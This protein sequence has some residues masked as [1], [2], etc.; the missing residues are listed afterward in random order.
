[1]TT[2]INPYNFV[3]FDKKSPMVAS[4]ESA[5]RGKENQKNLLSGWLEIKLTI[6]TPLIVPD[7]AHP[8]IYDYKEN[9]YVRYIN[10]T[11]N[12]H[13]EYSFMKIFNP[14]TGRKEYQIPG[15]ELRGMIRSAYEAVTNSCLPFLMDDKPMSQRVPLYGA[16]NRR[17][18]LQ[19]DGKRWVLYSTEKT[20]EE[21]VVVPVYEANREF[22]I[23][24]ISDKKINE[25]N[26]KYS[27]INN[28]DDIEEALK[29]CKIDS[30]PTHYG[31]T[32]KTNEKDSKKKDLFVDGKKCVS[33]IDGKVYRFLFVKADGSF[34]KQK[35][36]TY[37]DG[38]GWIQYNVPVD[39]T[40]VYH[41]AYLNKTEIVH[42]WDNNPAKGETGRNRKPD[43]TTAEAYYKLKSSLQRDGAE[44]YRNGQRVN[45]QPNRDCNFAIEEAL[46][47]AC[48]DKNTFVPVY[49]FTVNSDFGEIVYMSGSA[50]G[51][52]A[53]RRKWA[54]IMAGH[55]TCGKDLCPACLLFGTL[56]DGGMKTHI[57]I[58]DAY[59]EYDGEVRKSI[60][61]L[62][63]LA[64]PRPTAFEFYLNKPKKDNPGEKAIYSFWNYDFYGV[65]TENPPQ[66][67]Y[68]HLEKALPRGRKMYWHHTPSMENVT[69]GRMNSTMESIDEGVFNFKVYYDQISEKQLKDLI[70]VINLGENEEDGIMRHKLGHAKPLGYGSV[71][72]TIT[73][74]HVRCVKSGAENDYRM[75]IK[76]ISEIGINPDSVI[77]DFDLHSDSVRSFLRVCN[78]ETI[79]EDMVVD[80]PRTRENGMIYEWFSKNR[81]N[82]KRLQTLPHATDDN[83]YLERIKKTNNS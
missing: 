23:E 43:I 58:S 63:I 13:K 47:K 53:Q 50:A 35:P 20:L 16:L 80:Y 31:A 19:Y 38:K 48:K 4:K 49:F 3:P 8:K 7:A 59:M 39:L 73:D 55:T 56:S 28:W 60:H 1:M 70:W 51:R 41:I 68:Y 40:T 30:K 45:N 82:P 57:R 52:I 24:S 69:K 65:T 81:E 32:L 17:G 2:F 67:T 64:T 62:P 10:Q 71:K 37:V 61:T 78:A 18:L 44:S 15:S 22:Y 77:P 11:K 72:L 54:E 21:V 42:E 12:P 36:G 14:E 33:K 66:T 34:V 25:K 79:N 27:I 29:K 83:L 6:R 26:N 9:S 46:E 75:E 76:N 5:Y 74:G